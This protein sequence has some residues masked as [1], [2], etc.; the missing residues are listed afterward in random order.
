MECE[1]VLSSERN[2]VSLILRSLARGDGGLDK[3]RGDSE[4]DGL[5]AGGTALE[6]QGENFKGAVKKQT[7][8]TS[9]ENQPATT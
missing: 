1:W 5:N 6:L 9:E 3:N 4:L 7:C 2:L 8:T